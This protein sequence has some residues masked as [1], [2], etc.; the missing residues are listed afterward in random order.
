MTYR[1]KLVVTVAAVVLACVLIVRYLIYTRNSTEEKADEKSREVVSSL[2]GAVSEARYEHIPQLTN[3][4]DIIEAAKSAE[5]FDRHLREN[6]TSG[7]EGYTQE[8]RDKHQFTS[9]NPDDMR[10]ERLYDSRIVSV[11]EKSGSLRATFSVE[12]VDGR[13]VITN[14]NRGGGVAG[15]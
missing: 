4:T 2:I 14:M 1:K 5:K 11:G 12:E 9:L 7:V 15:L 13:H 6:G 8:E 3:S 10:V